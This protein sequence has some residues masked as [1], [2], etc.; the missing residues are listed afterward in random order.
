MRVRRPEKNAR[1]KDSACIPNGAEARKYYSMLQ[2]LQ[3]CLGSEKKAESIEESSDT[4]KP[5]FYVCYASNLGEK[6]E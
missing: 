1:I 2:L 3:G 4:R 6:E 5:A